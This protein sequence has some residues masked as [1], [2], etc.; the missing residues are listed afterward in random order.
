M[1]FPTSG[2]ANINNCRLTISPNQR[3]FIT[4]PHG[5]PRG[6]S[7]P[8]LGI[9]W[10]AATAISSQAV[11]EAELLD[12]QAKGFNTVRVW[13]TMHRPD[14]GGYCNS[15]VVRYLREPDGTFI[16][17]DVRADEMARL[18][19]IL[20]YANGLDMIVDVT[21]Q[22]GSEN[23]VPHTPEELYATW[24]LLA[25]HLNVYENIYFDIFCENEP[26]I[27]LSKNWLQTIVARVRTHQVA[28]NVPRLITCSYSVGNNPNQYYQDYCPDPEGNDLWVFCNLMPT[29]VIND[30][31]DVNYVNLD[32][33]APHLQQFIGNPDHVYEITG[34]YFDKTDG[35][36]NNA[37]KVPIH[38]QEPF[39]VWPERG[40]TVWPNRP[41][42]SD[43][44]SFYKD[45]NCSLAWQPGVNYGAA[46]WFFHNG[47]FVEFLRDMDDPVNDKLYNLM[48][49]VEQ[50]VYDNLSTTQYGLRNCSDE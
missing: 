23:G 41:D 29:D 46:G 27:Y 14:V 45:K 25:A 35:T 22:I 38:Y 6:F 13:A 28:G 26:S 50:R 9:S 18:H 2:H 12:F 30:Y 48:T 40:E 3:Q 5:S 42:Y 15:S 16:S 7:E 37:R 11:R 4:Y 47:Y 24:D 49:T 33:L 39:R 1:A 8:L 21:V 34:A 19:H 44:N 32:F 20:Q 17:V 36:G 10:F 31:L 43:W